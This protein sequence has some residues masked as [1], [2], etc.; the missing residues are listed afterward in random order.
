MNIRSKS[1]KIKESGNSKQNYKEK[2]VLE[3]RNTER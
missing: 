3:N 2:K 1:Q